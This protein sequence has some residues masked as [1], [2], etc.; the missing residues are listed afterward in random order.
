MHVLGFFSW[1]DWEIYP[2]K[3]SKNNKFIVLKTIGLL[4]SKGSTLTT[5]G[6]FIFDFQKLSQFSMVDFLKVGV[7][8]QYL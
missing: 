8:L 6:N 3:C 2:T 7:L 4:C 1:G 5:M